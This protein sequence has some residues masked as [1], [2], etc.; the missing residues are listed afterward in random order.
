MNITIAGLGLIGGS[1]GK[2]LRRRGWRVSY[3]DPAV[4][5]EQAGDAADEKLD[6]LGGELMVLAAPVDVSI[7]M[8]RS[9]RGSKSTVT[10]VCSVMQPLIDAAKG[11]RFIAGHPFAGSERTGIEAAREDLFAGRPWFLESTD[12][13]I[14]QMVR[15]TG[16]EPVLVDARQ[17]DDTLALT[18]HLPQLIVTALASLIETYHVD[19]RFLGNGVRSLL[20][21]AGSSYGVWRPI[22]DCNGENVRSWLAELDETMRQVSADDFERAHK[23]YERVVGSAGVSPAPDGRPAR[24]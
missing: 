22:L 23:L 14:D 10:S 19:D 3:V 1:L 13:Q 15:D 17:H 12:P 21:L 9:L 7:S 16:A 24:R 2:A 4:S 11:V 20:R 5:M 6:T 8:L 18:S